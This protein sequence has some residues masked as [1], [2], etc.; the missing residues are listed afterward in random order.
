MNIAFRT[1]AVVGTALTLLATANGV[2]AADPFV[3][4][5]YKDAAAKATGRSATAVIQTVVGSQLATDDCIV[6]TWSKSSFLD[7]GGKPRKQAYLFNLNCN[8]AVASAGSPGN[9]LASVEGRA[10]EAKIKA[11]EKAQKTAD[12]CAL[13]AQA[14]YEPCGTFW[15][16]HED[17]HAEMLKV[18]KANL[19]KEQKNAAWCSQPAQATFD[20]CVKFC[21][22]HDGLCTV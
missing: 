8:D 21:S 19:E 6:T 18:M 13:P 1:V 17:L 22:E 11:Q 5:T 14:S 20:P 4:L 12:W 16:S 10:A 3:G 2:S 9:S 7:I 15:K